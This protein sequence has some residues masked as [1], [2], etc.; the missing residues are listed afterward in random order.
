MKPKTYYIDYASGWGNAV[1]TRT[2]SGTHTDR[3][4]YPFLYVLKKDADTVIQEA[5]YQDAYRDSEEVVL[6]TFWK[7]TPLTLTKVYTHSPIQ[8]KRIAEAVEGKATIFAADINYILNYL[9]HQDVGMYEDI[10]TLKGVCIDIEIYTE[11]PGVPQ[12][13]EG[14]IVSGGVGRFE[15]D[16]ETL[17]II[18]DEVFT[19]TG[20][21]EEIVKN[22][23]K[24]CFKSE[25]VLGHNLGGFDWKHIA[26]RLEAARNFTT[27]KK[28]WSS[29]MREAEL[30]Y[31]RTGFFDTIFAAGVIPRL[32]TRQ[33]ELLC[34]YLGLEEEGSREYIPVNEKTT[35][36]KRDP[37]RLI[38]CNEDDVRSTLKLA[39]YIFPLVMGPCRY[40]GL[41]MENMFLSGPKALWEHLTM[42]WCARSG[43]IIPQY[44][45]RA[46]VREGE[47]VNPYRE[48]GKY[49]IKGAYTVHPKP[50]MY[51]DL[52]SIDL[53]ACYPTI[54]CN[55]GISPET[56]IPTERDDG[57]IIEWTNK[58]PDRV[59]IVG[60]GMMPQLLRPIMDMA[61]EL[62][63]KS[64][65]DKKYKRAYSSIK[66]LRN[67]AF[68]YMGVRG[69][70]SRFTNNYAAALITAKAREKIGEMEG[71]L[72]GLGL[73]TVSADTDG[74]YMV[75]TRPI[76]IDKI[77]RSVENIGFDVDVD[78]YKRGLFLAHKNYVL[79]DDED[80]LTIKGSTLV[81]RSYPTIIRWALRDIVETYL[82]EGRDAAQEARNR[83]IKRIKNENKDS[84]IFT[85][86]YSLREPDAYGIGE[87]HP[88]RQLVGYV[89]RE[90]R[91]KIQVSETILLYVKKG[92]TKSGQIKPFDKWAPYETFKWDLLDRSW[93][94]W[95]LDE[96]ILKK[97][98]HLNL[99]STGRTETYYKGN[100]YRIIDAWVK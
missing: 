36:W 72:K 11:E 22:L 16:M 58:K 28:N 8:V 55:L 42:K 41:P 87:N 61:S 44:I 12:P 99:A 71:I 1:V 80:K 94:S 96:Y 50:G 81:Q 52:Y 74:L 97:I 86:T 60:E 4:F 15:V 3:S 39:D 93:Y 69:G 76:T 70:H 63:K 66:G 49:Q 89:Q 10:E 17:S 67:A 68:G 26:A 24:E 54:I 90:L 62:K 51:E 48:V 64:K 84:Y 14:Q 46:T 13:G 98:L 35:I 27:K 40:A 18:P 34:M 82:L 56:V 21:E 75:A 32:P 29:F 9:I 92:S 6:K 5:I 95:F 25:L 7:K 57:Y 77:R 53:G 38:K 91:R 88:L 30:E 78:H 37:D 83:W 47:H 2:Q 73:R 23:Y 59:K 20:D 65:L 19:Y 100:K 31:P 45:S 33:L 43:I 79:V 85:F